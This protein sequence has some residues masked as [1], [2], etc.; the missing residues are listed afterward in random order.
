MKI[1][2]PLQDRVLVLPDEPIKKTDSGLFIPETAQ[3]K[4]KVGTVILT[5]DGVDNK[6]MLTR[7]GDRVMYGQY[8]GTEVKSEGRDYLMLRESDIICIVGVTQDLELETKGNYGL[9][10]YLDS[11]G[12]L[13]NLVS[14][15][16]EFNDPID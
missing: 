9:P 4:P 3:E 10:P 12:N 7:A 2:K 14:E 15:A 5:G 8:A 11:K 13:T 6:P 1:I 16:E